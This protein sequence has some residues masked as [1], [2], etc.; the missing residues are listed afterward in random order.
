MQKVIYAVG[1]CKFFEILKAVCVSHTLNLGYNIQNIL[2]KFDT[3]LQ[4]FVVGK[5]IKTS[6]LNGNSIITLP[7][8]YFIF[9]F[10]IKLAS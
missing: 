1:R 3:N 10:Y 5:T 8:N 4:Y 7:K 9:G 2:T 6:Y